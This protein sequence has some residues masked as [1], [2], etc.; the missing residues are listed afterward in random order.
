MILKVKFFRGFVDDFVA[1]ENNR[2]QKKKDWGELL[3]DK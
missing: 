1:G 2:Y 3:D